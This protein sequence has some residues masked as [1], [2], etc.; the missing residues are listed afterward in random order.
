[1]VAALLPVKNGR[2]KGPPVNASLTLLANFVASAAGFGR[3]FA[4]DVVILRILTDRV[5]RD[6]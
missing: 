3:G 2:G 1:M 4:A 6:A 5:W